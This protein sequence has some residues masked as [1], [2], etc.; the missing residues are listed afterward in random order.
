MNNQAAVVKDLDRFRDLLRILA[1]GF[2]PAST[3]RSTNN[4]GAVS[5]DAR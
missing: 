2:V 5:T 3:V 4:V 1:A